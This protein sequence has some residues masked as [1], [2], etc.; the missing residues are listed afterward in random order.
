MRAS[1]QI[2]R[3][4][5]TILGATRCPGTRRAN[6][7][8]LARHG[9]LVPH[10]ACMTA[11]SS[12]AMCFKLASASSTPYSPAAKTMTATMIARPSNPTGSVRALRSAC[13]AES[14]RASSRGPVRVC[15]CV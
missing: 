3:Y 8:S 13:L 12:P 6:T 11:V 10:S 4:G 5:T 9:L 2:L 15:V 7:I 1:Q 14:M